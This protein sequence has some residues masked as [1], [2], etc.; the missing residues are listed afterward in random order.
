MNE[1]NSFPSPEIQHLLHKFKVFKKYHNPKHK[2]RMSSYNTT[3]L[4][5]KPIRNNIV[6]WQI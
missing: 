5:L 4:F 3:H 1:K 6:L 2:N